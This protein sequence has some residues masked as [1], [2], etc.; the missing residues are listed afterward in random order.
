M[1]S[2]SNLVNQILGEVSPKGWEGTVKAMKDEPG[3]DNPWALAH[4]MKGEGYK[5]HKKEDGGEPFA[6]D[7]SMRATTARDKQSLSY[8]QTD[9]VRVIVTHGSGTTSGKTGTVVS[10]REV[11]TDG[12]GIPTNI[13][14]AY[15]P[16]DWDAEV[17]VRLDDGELI[18]M[19]KERLS[20]V[21]EQ[22]GGEE[23]DPYADYEEQQ[24]PDYDPGGRVDWEWDTNRPGEEMEENAGGDWGGP[25]TGHGMGTGT[26][27]VGDIDMRAYKEGARVV[28]PTKGGN[29]PGTVIA[30]SESGVTVDWDNLQE[31]LA[32]SAVLPFEDAKYLNI[33]EEYSSEEEYYSSNPNDVYEITYTDINKTVRMSHKKAEKEFG[34]EEFEEIKRGYSPNI[35]AVKVSESK[36]PKKEK[37]IDENL[38]MIAMAPIGG[39]MLTRRP[40]DDFNFALTY[41]DIGLVIEDDEEDDEKDDENDSSNSDK[42]W[43]KSS[44]SNNSNSNGR[45]ELRK[46]SEGGAD[47]TNVPRPGDTVLTNQES[48]PKVKTDPLATMD[49]AESAGDGDAP[50]G[51]YGSDLVPVDAPDVPDYRDGDYGNA[52]KAGSGE[53]DTNEVSDS[54]SGDYN[55]TKPEDKNKKVEEG[56]MNM[57]LTYADLG[58]KILNEAETGQGVSGYAEDYHGMR[59]THEPGHG[60]IAMSRELLDKLLMAVSKQSPEKEELDAI[61]QGL[62]SA[63]SQKGETLDVEDVDM[64]KSEMSK[65]FSGGGEEPAAPEG[66]DYADAEPD[67]APEGGEYDDTEQDAEEDMGGSESN[68]AGDTRHKAQGYGDGEGMG[69]DSHGKKADDYKGSA[70]SHEDKGDD[71]YDY[72]YDE[73]RA[74]GDGKVAGPEGGEEHEGK[75]QLMDKKGIDRDKDGDV[76]SDDWKIGRDKAIKRSKAKEATGSGTPVGTGSNSGPGGGSTQDLSKPK[77]QRPSKPLGSND[78]GRGPGGSSADEFGQKPTKDGGSNLVPANPD[79]SS[80][81][82]PQGPW[83]DTTELNPQGGKALVA[84]SKRKRTK[85]KGTKR[86]KQQVDEA[87]MLGMA[88]IPGTMRNYQEVQIENDDPDAEL[89]MMRRRAGIAKWWIIT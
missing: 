10:P 22:E 67:V 3:I 88:A 40:S 87:I 8:S 75:R 14:G 2:F 12:R 65:A 54:D 86:G 20:R 89:K 45:S 21:R 5:S 31:R 38:I 50:D 82:T 35:V 74:K 73:D 4:W 84:E 66:D 76:D 11:K 52:R 56:N 29:Q 23:G 42:P 39:T 83:S 28:H 13:Q 41:E 15:H 16:V 72:D 49:G 34:R 64:I 77:N 62:E 78:K 53:A 17:A 26:P 51:D 55:D 30:I 58:L 68:E 9:P 37:K 85:R 18:T 70:Y 19:Y 36:M 44:D 61:C 48:Q 6:G 60:E 27:Y 81:A 63:S 79:G 1:P 69:D 24:R 25:G 46:S 7:R 80:L 43:E 33:I 47:Y 32:T 59:E 71:Y 57:N